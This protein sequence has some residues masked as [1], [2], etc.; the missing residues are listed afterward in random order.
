MGGFNWN[1]SSFSIHSPLVK[2][3]F[4]KQEQEQNV[5]DI[6]GYS[7][8]MPE[9]IE[10]TGGNTP[11]LPEQVEA[12]EKKKVED[13]SVHKWGPALG[14]PVWKD[15]PDK[16]KLEIQR[17]WEMRKYEL[18]CAL[19]RIS[20]KGAGHEEKLAAY[21]DA[22]MKLASRK[23]KRADQASEDALLT[24]MTENMFVCP[25]HA[26]R[27]RIDECCSARGCSQR[28]GTPASIL[29]KRD[30]LRKSLESHEAVKPEI[31]AY[32]YA[33]GIVAS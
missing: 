23:R 4:N 24:T 8:R 7:A 12:F 2:Q 5:Q 28:A 10:L 19:K 11:L 21:K 15:K 25:S 18:L 31:V 6:D 20:G 26:T 16:G 17:E 13:G 22:Y 30:S 29:K 14:V 33:F 27:M 9:A 32:T 3:E 1:E